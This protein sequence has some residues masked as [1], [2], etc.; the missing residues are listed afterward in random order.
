MNDKQAQS[1]LF[2]FICQTKQQPKKKRKK[3][4]LAPRP[5]CNDMGANNE[6]DNNID[7]NNKRI[8]F[9]ISTNQTHQ[10]IW[11]PI[12]LFTWYISKFRFGLAIPNEK[13]VE[14]TDMSTTTFLFNLRIEKD[15]I[16]YFV[17]QS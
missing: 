16:F 14:P 13:C 10:P 5:L 11:S 8:M 12:L 1:L 9:N 7:N 2:W 15:F 6:F 17:S 3:N 4:S